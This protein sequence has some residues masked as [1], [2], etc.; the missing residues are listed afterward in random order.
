MG[1][2]G[3][4]ENVDCAYDVGRRFV[5]NIAIFLAAISI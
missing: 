1:L 4:T 2:A 5:D 3:A